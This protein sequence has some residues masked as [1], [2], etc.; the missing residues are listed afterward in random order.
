[1]LQ[2]KSIHVQ[3]DKIYLNEKKA[4]VVPFDVCDG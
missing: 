1:M 2:L 3:I 4:V